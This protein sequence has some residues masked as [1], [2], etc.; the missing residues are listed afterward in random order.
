[1][2]VSWKGQIQCGGE[3]GRVGR[4]REGGHMRKHYF[5]GPEVRMKGEVLRMD[6]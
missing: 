3:D 5:G 1:M 4:V 6:E 2:T